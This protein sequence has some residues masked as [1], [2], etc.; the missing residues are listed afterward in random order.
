MRGSKGTLGTLFLISTTGNARVSL[1][2]ELCVTRQ[3][4]DTFLSTSSS[5]L[6]K[7]YYKGKK[8]NKTERLR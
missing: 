8:K 4:C 7:S 2:T 5:P 6:S 1:L 3:H